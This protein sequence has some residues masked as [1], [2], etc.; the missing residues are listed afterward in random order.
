MALPSVLQLYYY[1]IIQLYINIE[2][3]IVKPDVY[4]IC[5]TLQGAFRQYLLVTS[6]PVSQRRMAHPDSPQSVAP[7]ERNYGS[8]TVFSITQNMH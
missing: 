1:Y 4:E 5:A 6:L 2:K 7:R 8:S 3:L